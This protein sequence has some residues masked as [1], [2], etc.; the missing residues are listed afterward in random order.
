MLTS[1]K[2]VQITLCKNV[3]QKRVVISFCQ[4]QSRK[5][6]KE[7]R[8]LEEHTSSS[9]LFIVIKSLMI[10]IAGEKSQSFVF[11]MNCTLKSGRKTFLILMYVS[12]PISIVVKET[13]VSKIPLQIFTQK[14]EKNLKNKK[15][16]T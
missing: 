14:L 11:L 12:N 10:Q 7:P 2:N 15:K 8:L 16:N 5:K 13:L 4:R 9:K 6:L 1:G 3:L